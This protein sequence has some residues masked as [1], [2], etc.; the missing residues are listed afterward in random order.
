MPE[1]EA[2]LTRAVARTAGA[3]LRV[4]TVVEPVEI[5]LGAEGNSFAG[6]GELARAREELMRSHLDRGL[7]LVPDDIEVSGE[8]A[9]PG[10]PTLADQEDVDVLIVGSR[11][12]GPIRRLLLGSVST[13]L[14]RSA[15]CPLIVYPRGAERGGEESHTIA[16]APARASS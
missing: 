13:R 16:G 14:V 15:P 2:A 4:L 8:L 10:M 5:P 3:S 1:S 11:G 9:T 7:A 6:V 12:Y